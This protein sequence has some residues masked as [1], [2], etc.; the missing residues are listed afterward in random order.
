MGAGDDRQMGANRKRVL[1]CRRAEE[2]AQWVLGMTENG[3][4]QKEGIIL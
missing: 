3:G 2:Q 4:K 1:F